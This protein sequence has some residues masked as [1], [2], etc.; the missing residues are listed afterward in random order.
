[1]PYLIDPGHLHRA[2]R[3][4]MRRSSS[5]GVDGLSWAQYR[6][7]LR[8][9]LAGLAGRL[10]EGSWVPAPLREV[11]IDTYTGKTMRAGIPTVEDRIVHRAIRTAVDPILERRAYAPWVSGYRPGRNRL[12]AVR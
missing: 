3:A 7:G 12:T 4:C 6:Q 8:E 2:A 11:T 5:P 9:R 1:M 10:H